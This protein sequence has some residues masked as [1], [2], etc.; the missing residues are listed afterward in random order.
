VL[1]CRASDRAAALGLGRLLRQQLL[2][3]A[4]HLAHRGS[5]GR[6][7][8]A[9]VGVRAGVALDRLSR[10]LLGLSGGGGRGTA[11]LRC[12][13][14]LRLLHQLLNQLRRL[15][16]ALHLG[17]A[18]GRGR[19]SHRNPALAATAAALVARAAR[20]GHGRHAAAGQQVAYDVLA[21]LRPAGGVLLEVGFVC[22]QARRVRGNL[23]VAHGARLIQVAC[24]NQIAHSKAELA[25]LA[26]LLAGAWQW[27][28]G[29]QCGDTLR[30]AERGVG[31]S[32]LG[33]R[34]KGSAAAECDPFLQPHSGG[35]GP[36]GSPCRTCIAPLDSSCTERICSCTSLLRV[37][38]SERSDSRSAMLSFTSCGWGR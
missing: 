26:P 4:R 10:R 5:R 13:R 37:S 27:G 3:R 22:Q 18:L 12:D 33:R 32:V 17:L 14:C 25:V 36:S 1:G 23:L 8:R 31:A 11:A 16:R 21:L 35:S 19:A 20:I 38:T 28:R 9:A 24:L 7:V 15:G 30:A 2:S 29:R 34:L 6:L